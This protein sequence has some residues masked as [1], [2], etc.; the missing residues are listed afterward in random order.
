MRKWLSHWL[1][2]YLHD[3]VGGLVS[4]SPQGD[5]GPRDQVVGCPNLR[6][7]QSDLDGPSRDLIL[8]LDLS[9]VEGRGHDLGPSSGRDLMHDPGPCLD[10]YRDLPFGHVHATVHG[11]DCGDG[12][13]R[14]HRG[15]LDDHD[16]GL[17]P[18]LRDHALVCLLGVYGYH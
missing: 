14:D 12:K 16:H 11:I 3:L 18:N 1:R 15:R 5:H 7:G 6:D 9:D 10:L 2:G 4:K 17:L 13:D 8:D